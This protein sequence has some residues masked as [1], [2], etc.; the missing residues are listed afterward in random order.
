MV[1]DFRDCDNL[2]CALPPLKPRPHGRCPAFARTSVRVTCIFSASTD[3]CRPA[4]T[5]HICA[6]PGP[7]G[8]T[9]I[10]IHAMSVRTRFYRRH[11][12]VKTRPWVKTHPR[13]KR[14][15]PDNKRRHLDEADVW[16]IN[17]TVGRPF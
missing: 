3:P 4:R 2:G 8:P 1:V 17:F 9:P 7:R 16:T 11:G 15:R 14:G 10:G 13:D 5:R 12:P 6:D